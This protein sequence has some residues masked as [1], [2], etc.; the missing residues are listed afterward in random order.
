MSKIVKDCQKLS[1]FQLLFWKQKYLETHFF[2]PCIHA[3]LC[4]VSQPASHKLFFAK[5]CDIYAMSEVLF[6]FTATF[7]L[8]LLHFSTKTATAC[9][10]WLFCRVSIKPY[11]HSWLKLGLS[12]TKIWISWKNVPFV[13]TLQAELLTLC[14]G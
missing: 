12:L 9:K 11:Y 3:K 5:A 1:I 8:P 6:R 2:A 13:Q 7:K 10:W 14:H 4:P